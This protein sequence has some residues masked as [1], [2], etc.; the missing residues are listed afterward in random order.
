MI[1]GLPGAIAS[2]PGALPGGSPALIGI[3]VAP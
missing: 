2:T 3:H 1:L